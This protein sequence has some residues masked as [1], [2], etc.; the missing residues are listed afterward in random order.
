MQDQVENLKK[1]GIKAAAIHSG[2]FAA[3]IETAL[4]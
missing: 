4:Q 1:K 2:M 3:E